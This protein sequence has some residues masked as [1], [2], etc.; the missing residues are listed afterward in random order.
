MSPGCSLEGLTLK[1]KHQYFGHLMQ[2]VE[3][4]EN[5]LMLEKIEGRKR[6]GWQ[7]TRWLDGISNSMDMS[8]VKLRELVM[9][10]EGWCAE[11]HG[12]VKSR[13]WLSEWTELNRTGLGEIRDSALGEY[14]LNH[15]SVLLK[16]VQHCKSTIPQN[17]IKIVLK[18][19]LKQLLIPI[20]IIEN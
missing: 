8:L 17:K 16:L 18:N 1:L 9:D 19:K 7:R 11:V 4:F 3:S 6:R 10:R 12:V 15:F 5:T 20:K 14:T 13:T 2:R